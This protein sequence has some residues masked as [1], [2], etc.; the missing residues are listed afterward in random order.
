MFQEQ[1]PLLPL[2][3]PPV[4]GRR[5]RAVDLLFG[6]ALLVAGYLAVAAVVIAVSGGNQASEREPGVAL[7]LAAATLCFEVWIGAL[8]LLLA[9]RRGLA[10]RDLG[11][12]RPRDWGLVAFTVLGAYGAV[13]GYSLLIAGIEALTGADLGRLNQGNGLPST[14][15][16]SP[17][18]WATLGVA[19]MIAA[20]L[21]E[22]LFFRGLVFRA[23]AA[24]RG[25]VTGIVVSGVAFA[26]V[27]FNVS[28]VVPFAA[29]GMIFAWS[30]RT[31][32][33]LWT[34]IAAHAIFNT[35]SFVLTLAG[36]AR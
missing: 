2:P 8:V 1:P 30:Y 13:I 15:G 33:S 32:G 4:E 20:P 36:A 6:A 10:L 24:L 19:V 17:L 18:V 21:C 7:L 22:E 16:S 3:A 29:I 14:V 26:L 25:P 31:S 9:R 23:L 5:W 34:T 12:H 11:F 35:I 27:H 28:V